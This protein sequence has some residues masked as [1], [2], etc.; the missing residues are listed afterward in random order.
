MELARQ[1]LPEVTKKAAA[2]VLIGAGG[3]LLSM[4]PEATGLSL[5]LGL[6][7]GI[8]GSGSSL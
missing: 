7:L 5:D 4:P 1:A 6:Q 2:L 8:N 3:E